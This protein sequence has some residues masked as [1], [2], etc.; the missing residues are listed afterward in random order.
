MKQSKTPKHS[1][2]TLTPTA[3]NLLCPQPVNCTTI[4]P[5]QP[6]HLSHAPIS[7]L[8]DNL[9]LKLISLATR[10]HG[11]QS[12]T[13]GTLSLLLPA[14]PILPSTSPPKLHVCIA[15]SI[16]RHLDPNRAPSLDNISPL[17][18]KNVPQNWPQILRLLS[19]LLL[20][21][22]ATFGTAHPKACL[23]LLNKTQSSA[24]R[25]MKEPTLS[26]SNFLPAL[27]SS[28]CNLSFLI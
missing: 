8:R 18:P 10:W 16:L 11:T 12:L 15:S 20:W 9:Y 5:T 14:R 17:V 21:T 2:F 25:F 7:P 3:T 19:K 6:Y 26:F 23:S 13:Q 27:C 28:F 1:P 4:S 24:A 22:V